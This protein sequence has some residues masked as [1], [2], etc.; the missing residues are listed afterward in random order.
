MKSL[1]WLVLSVLSAGITFLSVRNTPDA[2][3]YSAAVK[4]QMGDLYSPWVGARELLL[5]HR[6]PYGPEVSEQIQTAFYGHTIH[7]AYDAPAKSL[8][9][10]QRFAYPVYVVF[11]LAPAINADFLE[12]RQWARLLLAGFT[13]ISVLLCL[14]ILHWH[15]TRTVTIALILFI[16]SSPQLI[17]GLRLEQ[18]ALVV[19]FLLVASAWCAQKN[20][21]I[22]VGV[23][24]ALT[25]IKPQMSVMPLCWF[26]IWTAGKWR[27]RWRIAAAFVATL[28]ALIAG[29]EI[30]LHGWIRYFVDGLSAYRKYAHTSSLLRVLLGD[31]LGGIT[32]AILFLALL[33]F[34]WRNRKAPSG[35]PEFTFLFAVFLMGAV[36]VFPLL[37]PFNQVMLILPSMLVLRDW[38][39]LS[40]FS[41]FIF[42]AVI[43]WTW[44]TD[45]AL[46]ILPSRLQSRGRLPFFA[47]LLVSFFP[48]FLL[49]LNITKRRNALAKL[50]SADL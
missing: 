8:I 36:L 4:V 37:I 11:L 1:V 18:L 15:V 50:A 32:A 47:S 5:H 21:L 30:L 41:R 31:A 2:W 27:K 7:Q 43:S 28:A 38:K 33:L 22:A 42:I 44:I 35:S 14:D 19:G 25:T 34:A 12:V 20:Y 13:A 9:N 24:L 16:L 17:Q 48:L 45:L 26:A 39:A 46:L 3:S 6:N 10:E 49:L 29:G 23:L 40:R